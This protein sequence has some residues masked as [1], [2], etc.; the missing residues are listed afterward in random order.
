MLHSQKIE[1]LKVRSRAKWFEENEINESYFKQLLAS[2]KKKTCIDK[3]KKENMEKEI[4]DSKD[5]LKEIK[6][7]YH[8][9]YLRDE[10]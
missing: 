7:F 6:D 10:R 5:I 9:L 2:N 4:T 1:G 8:T 3:L